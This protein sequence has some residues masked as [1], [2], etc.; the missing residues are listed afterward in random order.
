ME[1]L[2]QKPTANIDFLTQEPAEHYHAQSKHYLGSHALADFRRSPLLYHR[3]KAG[4]I[5]DE[6]RPAYLVGRAAHV[7]ILEGRAA[8][9]EQF[10]IGGPVNPKTGS[11]YG[12]RTKAFADWATAQGK[13]VLTDDQLILVQEMHAGIHRNAY[14]S[15][16]LATG[17]AEGVVRAEYCGL[18]CQIRLD[19]FNPQV[20]IV[21]LKTCDDLTWFEPD[22]RRYGY[23]HQLAFYRSVL[24]LVT[25]QFVSVFL[26]AV[27]K[28]EPFRCGVWRIGDDILGIAKCENEQAMARIKQCQSHDCWPTGYEEMRSFDSL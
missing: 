27:E 9:E 25:P 14:A 15:E 19:W 12:S 17:Q 10:A 8:F 23:I 3:K 11:L 7:L 1:T 6:D 21:D 26:I 18:P 5:Q 16:L 20:G 22:A 24:Q 13:P 2:M 28:K 4:F